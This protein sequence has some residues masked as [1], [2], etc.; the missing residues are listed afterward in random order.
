MPTMS[1]FDEK[2]RKLWDPQV[3]LGILNHGDEPFTCVGLTVSQGRR[4]ENSLNESKRMAS[5]KILD[6]LAFED[7]PDCP[8][9][10][11]WLQV[12]A[13]YALCMR[14]HQSQVE[15]TVRTWQQAM[16]DTLQSKQKAQ[17]VHDLNLDSQK[18][19]IQT[20]VRDYLVAVTSPQSNSIQASVEPP[21]SQVIDSHTTFDP[22][23]ID[24]Y[25][26]GSDSSSDPKSVGF[27]KPIDLDSD[28]SKSQQ[29]T[30]GGIELEFGMH[31]SP[32]MEEAED[33]DSIES[34]KRDDTRTTLHHPGNENEIE[35]SEEEEQYYEYDEEDEVEE[36]EEEEDSD[37]DMDDEDEEGQNANLEETD[38]HIESDTRTYHNTTK[39]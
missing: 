36:E 24:A 3:D 10:T 15:Q 30:R 19:S 5:F 38:Q 11:G 29:T 28:V 4:C 35:E 20:D 26:Y 33:E 21:P 13:E 32:A 9:V 16:K 34:H 6:W 31:K 12:L 7:D 1:T 2:E 37:A 18:E 8:E 17:T 27:S 25:L 14:R 39:D 22:D 23:S